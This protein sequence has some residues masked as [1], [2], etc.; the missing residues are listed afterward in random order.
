[1]SIQMTVLLIHQD[2][3]FGRAMR[4]TLLSDG[5][6]VVGPV[7]S[8]TDAYL[9]I[10]NES[11]DIAI[12]D[13]QVCQNQSEIMSDTLI[14]IGVEHLILCY[15]PPHIL[16]REIGHGPMRGTVM[17]PHKNTAEGISHELCYLRAEK[18]RRDTLRPNLKPV[19]LNTQQ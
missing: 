1:M 4:E 3:T 6:K 18:I 10:L 19:P 12:L 8:V 13:Q 7:N 16:K 17:T 2:E 5:Y 15:N 9:A 11:P 14:Q